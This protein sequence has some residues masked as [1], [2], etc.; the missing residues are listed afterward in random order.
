MG[1]NTNEYKLNVQKDLMKNIFVKMLES[2]IAIMEFQLTLI[3]E[4]EQQKGIK[5]I[6]K[7]SK[8]AIDIIKKVKHY[9]LLVS[10]YNS[11]VN[12]KETYFVALCGTISSGKIKKW[13]S[14]KG[15]K[16]FLEEE[17]QAIEKYDKEMAEKIRQNDAIKKAKEE[18]K[19][20]EMMYVD[21]KIKPVIVNEKPN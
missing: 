17:A 6:I 1:L 18:G 9:E 2:N 12:R 11:F 5:D 20:V 13:D 4:E 19:K 3:K 21:G 7:K 10:L 16:E 8:K 14:E 15:F